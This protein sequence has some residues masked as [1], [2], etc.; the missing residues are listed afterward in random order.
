MHVCNIL[1]TDFRTNTTQEIKKYMMLHEDEKLF[2]AVQAY[3]SWIY[4]HS[5]LLFQLE[6]KN[7]LN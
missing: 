5:A 6:V 1:E 7:H 4:N 3:K 2:L